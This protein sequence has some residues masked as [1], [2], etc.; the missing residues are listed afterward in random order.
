[1]YLLALRVFPGVSDGIDLNQINGLGLISVLPPAVFIAIGLLIVAFF[2]TLTQSA[3]RKGLL[4][5]QLVAVM[6]ALHGAAALIESEPRFHTAW[7][8]AGFSEYTDAQVG[9]IIDYLEAGHPRP[10]RAVQLAGLLRTL[11]VR[12]QGRRYR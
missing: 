11:R 6:F 4:L 9:R 12:Q 10:G 2:V 3:D 8:H 7:V 5:F 1:M